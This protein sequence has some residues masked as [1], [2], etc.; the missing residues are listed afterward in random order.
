MA[1][2][3]AARSA[4]QRMAPGWMAERARRY[5]RAYRDREGVTSLAER[6]AAEHGHRVS[7]GPFQGLEYHRDLA[8]VDAPIAKLAGTY[9]EELHDAL[10]RALASHPSRFIDFGCADGY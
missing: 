7:G 1:L 3:Q 6:F 5:E 4:V 10:E 2:R 8:N 9:E